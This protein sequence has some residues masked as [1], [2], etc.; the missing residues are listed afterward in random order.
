M[1][2]VYI[3]GTIM[4]TVYGQLVL[5]WRMNRIDVLPAGLLEKLFFLLRMIL[6]SFVLSG[7][8]SAFLA[9]LFWMAA[10]TKFELSYAYPFMSLSFLAVFIGSIVL[11][12]EAFTWQKGL[13]LVFVILGIVISSQ[14]G[15]T[16]Q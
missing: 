8:V 5:K 12:H 1:G 9:S 6:D 16:N 15:I 4:F 14:G 13:G 10:M 11:F 7:L 2:Y 3:L